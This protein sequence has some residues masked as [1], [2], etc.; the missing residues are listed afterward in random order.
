[1]SLLLDKK[2]VTIAILMGL[3]IL[4]FSN[5]RYLVAMLVF[6]FLAVIATK[7]RHEKKKSM[8]IY[9]HERGWIN[10]LSNGVVPTFLAILSP[11]IGGIPY[12]CSIAAITADKFGSEL[13]VL[14]GEPVSLENFKKVKQGTSG[15]ISITGLILSIAGALFIGV[16]AILIFNI[17]PTKALIIATAGFVGSL[18]DSLFGVL[19]EK[20]IG[21][22]G[23]TNLICS[24]TGGLVGYLIA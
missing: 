22:K 4:I 24:I 1:M 9:E 16:T 11:Q 23:T 19:E 17:T 5:I 12:L 3:I 7:Y 18:V 14:G 8:G 6:L 13:G 20:G 21:T 2:G 15:A 10:V